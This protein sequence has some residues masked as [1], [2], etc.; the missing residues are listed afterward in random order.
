MKYL[1]VIWKKDITNLLSLSRPDAF[2]LLI[3]ILADRIG[4]PLNKNH[5]SVQTGISIAT[6]NKYLWYAEKDNLS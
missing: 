3:R 2:V 5:L 4:S 1:A 6:L